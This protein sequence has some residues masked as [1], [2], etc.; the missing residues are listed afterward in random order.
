MA[1]IFTLKQHAGK[2]NNMLGKTL[3]Y[4][5]TFSDVIV[6]MAKLYEGE[7]MSNFELHKRCIFKLH[8]HGFYGYKHNLV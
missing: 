7:V 5:I 4:K 1:T 6:V 2:K 3:S 8:S